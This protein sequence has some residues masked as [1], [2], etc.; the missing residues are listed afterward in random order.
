MEGVDV[1][2]TT[3]YPIH[4]PLMDSRAAL[5][6]ELGYL[7]LCKEDGGMCTIIMWGWH[8][9]RNH[10]QCRLLSQDPSPEDSINQPPIPAY[11]LNQF[12]CLINET[13]CTT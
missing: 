6:Y 13:T 11:H 5:L 1:M 10:L 12:S 2:C 8:M 9:I 3:V 4:P 7:V